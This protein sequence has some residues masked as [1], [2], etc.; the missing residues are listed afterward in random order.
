MMFFI[1]LFKWPFSLTLPANFKSGTIKFLAF[2]T[3]PVV[4]SAGLLAMSG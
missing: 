3:Y 2:I 4:T 1:L